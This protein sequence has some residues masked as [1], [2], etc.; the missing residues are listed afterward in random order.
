MM[1]DSPLLV[2]RDYLIYHK[3]PVSFC[4][5][6]QWII[7]LENLRGQKIILKVADFY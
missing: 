5:E 2:I 7:S 4:A 6:I 3:E 1:S